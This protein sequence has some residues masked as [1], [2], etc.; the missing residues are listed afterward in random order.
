M[1]LTNKHTSQNYANPLLTTLPK[2]D[3]KLILHLLNKH[4]NLTSSIS[5]YYFFKH[6]PLNFAY[7]LL[8]FERILENL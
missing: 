7:S 8:Y 1:L 6:A 2:S 4:Q 3:Q 5:S